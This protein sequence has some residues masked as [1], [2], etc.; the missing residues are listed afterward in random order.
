[1]SAA[2]LVAALGALAIAVAQPTTAGTRFEGFS[3]ASN[4]IGYV[5]MTMDYCDIKAAMA[6]GNFTEALSIYSTGKNSFTSVARRTFFRFATYAPANGSVEMLHDSI[7][8]GKNTSALDSAIRDALAAGKATLAAGLI[9]VATLKYHLH[10]VDG[11]FDKIRIYLADG[12]GNLT[13]LIADLTGAPHNVDEAW[14][15]W[16]GG[17]AKHCGTLSSWAAG[18]GAA[19]GTT[20]LGDSYINA[21]MINVQNEMQAA[22][23][24]ATLNIKAFDAARADEARV[25]TMLGLQGVSVAAYTADAANACKRP[26]AEVQDAKD[27]IAV[28]WMYLEGLLKL[29]NVKA[30]AV[31]ELHHALTATQLSYKKVAA[32][33]KGVLSAMGRRSS[34]LGSPQSSVIAGSWKC[35]S[36]VLRSV[37]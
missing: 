15:L 1:M 10:E 21:A 12:T 22:S 27:M 19:M 6:A 8:A 2:L 23:R 4:V 34:E 29:R 3:Y 18:L 17:A 24:N 20:F 25:L 14:A 26:A 16:A 11:A 37:A 28:H 7:L 30:A 13:S 31:T 5:N 33:V 32:A 36:K 9:Q 35:S